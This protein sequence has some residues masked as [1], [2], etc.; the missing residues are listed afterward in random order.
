M[1]CNV[2][3]QVSLTKIYKLGVWGEVGS[4]VELDPEPGL[5]EV[6]ATCDDGQQPTAGAA[7]GSLAELLLPHVELKKS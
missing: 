6:C 3:L 7:I 1:I 5:L 2:A 4:A